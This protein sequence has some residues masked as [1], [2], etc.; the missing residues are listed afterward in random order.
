MAY[1]M[2]GYVIVGISQNVSHVVVRAECLAV[3]SLGDSPCLRQMTSARRNE[4]S[5]SCRRAVIIVQF[6]RLVCLNEIG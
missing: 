4:C 2:L 1:N 3:D 5:P 6:K